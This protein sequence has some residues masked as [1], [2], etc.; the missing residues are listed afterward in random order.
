MSRVSGLVAM[1]VTAFVALA[2]DNL[3][4]DPGFEET[5]VAGV[6]RTG[7]RAG[8]LRVDARQ[9][10][11]S[12]GGPLPVE[13][14]A[15]YRATAWAKAT[16]GAGSEHA[17]Y[18]YQ[19]DSYVWAFNTY[20]SIPDGQDWQRFSVTFRVPQDQVFLHPLAFFGAA[21]TEA[22]IDDVVVEQVMSAEETIAALAQGAEAQGSVQGNDARLLARW[23]AAQGAFAKAQTVLRDAA[24]P[25]VKADIACVIAKAA[26]D[27]GLRTRMFMA[28]LEFG[29][30]KLHAGF[31]RLWEVASKLDADN[32]FGAMAEALPAF[33]ANEA[34]LDGFAAF[35]AYC[36][37][38]EQ[39]GIP[40]PVAERRA[41][42]GRF[43]AALAKVAEKLGASA[44]D[45]A[46]LLKLGETAK[47]WERR[48]EEEAQQLGTCQIALGGAALGK[49]THA[50]VIAEEPTPQE[51][52]A[53]L[54]L[55]MH[56]ERITGQAIPILSD[57]A[58]SGKRCLSIGRNAFTE[59]LG[60]GIDYDALG[61]EGIRIVTKGPH[62]VLSGNKR[63]VLYATYVFLEDHLGCRWFA[64]DCM[65]WPTMGAITVGAL[66]ITYVPAL[67]YRDTD[68]P[69]CRPAVFGVRNRLNGKCAHATDTWG[70]KIDYRGFVHTFRSLVPPS[71]YFAQHP[72]YFSEIGGARVAERA[73]LC[74]TN[75]DVLRIATETVKRWIEESPDAS[76]ISVS[77]NDCR[78]YCTCAKCTALAEAEGS[79]S[80]P[81]LHFVNGIAAAIAQE[82][83][84]IIID[85]L[86]YQYTRK[87][88]KHVKP[89]PNVAVRLCS[90]E[91]EF[92]RPLATSPFN[93]AFVADIKGW[94][95]KCDR[96]HIWDYV[97]NYAHCV[98]PFPNL[99]VL[100]PNIKFFIENGVTGIYEEANYFSKGG[101]FAELRTYIMA[102]LLWNPDY[103]VDTAIDEFCEAYYGRCWHLIREY[104]DDIHRRAV[105]DPDFHM[106]IGAPPQ[107]PFQ[108]DE[109]IA[110][111]VGLFD[112]AEAMMQDDPVRLHRVQVARLPVMYTQLMHQANPVSRL[113]E[114]AL[115][116]AVQG[117]TPAAGLAERFEQIARKEGLTRIAES[118]GRGPLD[119]WL[120][121]V[122]TEAKPLP[123]IR[124][125]GG[126]IEAVIV[127]GLGGRILSLKHDGQEMMLV[128][129]I[130][131]G[132]DP[133]TGGYKEFSEIG[134]RSPGWI[135]PYEVIEQDA[136]SVVV[137]CALKNG[138]KIRRRY[139]VDPARPVLRI[140]S[141]LTNTKSAAKS[142][143]LRVHPCFHLGDAAGATLRL[144][145]GDTAKELPLDR[146]AMREQELTMQGDAMPAGEWA[147]VDPAA[148]RSV[149]SR[150]NP[151][152]VG[153]CYF[154]WN[155]PQHR[156]NPELWTATQELQPGGTL[157]LEHEYEFVK[158]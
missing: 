53:A 11:A 36:T 47:Q 31:E 108:T 27:P 110:K 140:A 99:Y 8:Y 95:Q 23:Y 16:V 2:A 89:L 79:Q 38:R 154:N 45:H 155:G 14:Y 43:R 35:A 87:P 7:E 84:D 143:C 41:E 71:E 131:D 29:A 88:P 98:Q 17:L 24:D 48:I 93:A 150:F 126:G 149:I 113:T 69:N 158:L 63:G 64:P 70:G 156:V 152:Q 30:P 97:I 82:H 76:I 103:D 144:G 118:R 90:I 18:V 92:N 26:E 138:F 125:R 114:D 42:L 59:S 60:L 146:G 6:A 28:M 142:T 65:T 5:G 34:V 135:E 58:C 73:Q 127:P 15:T 100:Q 22:W 50:I 77:Q 120:D 112:N 68:Y 137:E 49:D 51:N 78:N 151:S 44:Q 105:S 4:P 33:G 55:Q 94:N 40:A 39:G 106:T 52:T 61:I 3:Y 46:A 13:P 109:A 54:D 72:E 80:G 67:E 66:D 57:A 134:Y 124:L 157:T 104:I 10:W 91:C 111:Y 75:P 9:H 136:R 132:I 25:K 85:T 128:T 101:E 20:A 121:T 1:I 107:S 139:E 116:P 81:L 37:G 153:V 145:A 133:S 148:G 102:K 12:I 56:L 129:E 141:T 86:A 62:V 119:T 115:A 147:F 74:L 96:L 32:P 83:P 122:R 117:G 21:N 123:V 130:E 19:W